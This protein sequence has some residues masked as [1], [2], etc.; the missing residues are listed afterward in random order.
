LSSPTLGGPATEPLP[1]EAEPPARV[2]ANSAWMLGSQAF[3]TLVAGIVSIYAVRN[4]A[5]SAWG[6]YSTAFALVVVFSVFAGPGLSSLALRELTSDRARQ[7]EILGVAFQALAW[8]ACVAAVAL[9]ATTAL[10]GYPRAVFALVVVLAPFL[11]LD[12]ALALTTAAFNARSKLVYA[13]VTKV[14][15]SAVYGTLAVVFI[16]ASLGVNGL[17]AA[18]VAAAACAAVLALV[19]LRRKLGLRPRLRQ[20]PSRARSMLRAA[21][22]LGGVT[23][24][25]VVYARIDVLML[26]V[27]T[28]SSR[29]AFYTVPFGF[30]RLSWIVPSVVA[31]AFF[32]LLS[33][34]LA[35]DRAEAEYLFFL[36][37]RVFFFLSV[38]ISL[39]LA[40]SSPTLLPFVYG[41][42][43]AGSVAVLQIMAWTSVFGFQNYVLWYGVLAARKEAAAFG[44]QVVGLVV[45][46]AINAF[47]IPLYGPRGAAAA[48]IVSD[49]VVVAG[50]TLLIHRNL[51]PVPLGRLLAKPIVAGAVAVPAAVLI[52][53]R[54]ALAGALAGAAA[55]ALVLQALG[56]VSAAEWRPVTA[57]LRVPFTRFRQGR[58]SST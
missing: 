18:A 12:T 25:G 30:V 42:Q 5:T 21:V 50:Q 13:A 26:S 40:V 14:V 49:L 38:P 28:S 20:A 55:Y 52:A 11:F 57:A 44:V 36:V 39:L 37:V 16:A 32:P 6:H 7:S 9:F 2:V 24:V 17:A 47:A 33:R 51:F 35:S 58:A 31:A 34:R 29:V 10:L 45:N 53:T 43:Y 3:V 56:Y 54:S 8:T 22:P 1:P 27:L 46:V 19:L 41:Q 23:L 4:L 48:L 15:Q